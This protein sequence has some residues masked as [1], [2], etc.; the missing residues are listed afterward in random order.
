MSGRLRRSTRTTRGRRASRTPTPETQIPITVAEEVAQQLAGLVPTLVAQL[1]ATL[2]PPT[3][4]TN[5]IQNL[6][7]QLQGNENERP[8][9]YGQFAKCK[10]TTFDGTGGPLKVNRWIE[11]MES[12]MDISHC[13]A[14]NKVRY[15]AV[16]LEGNALT[17]WNG[18]IAR[19][20]RPAAIGMSWE[21]FKALL[22]EEYCPRIER[23]KLE[24]E[25]WTHA[26][27]GS[28]HVAYTPR[29]HELS[30]LC[31]RMV[32][33]D[34]DR[35]ELY[36]RGLTPQ[37]RAL[38][39]ASNPSTLQGAI[40]RAAAITE[41]LVRA[42]TLSKT[43]EKRKDV[44][45]SSRGNRSKKSKPGKAFAANTPIQATP[46]QAVPFQAAHVQRNYAAPRPY[47]GPHPQ[48]QRCS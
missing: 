11:S 12:V 43:S 38:V 10:P 32:Q 31:P 7:Y 4:G 20:T 45:E 23:Q 16:S 15:A 28:N 8:I 17:W 25:F 6:Q 1:A 46:V 34:T 21:D 30:T 42:G 24:M 44:A 13:N 33:E 47:Q 19:R 40:T 48:C 3:G 9:D 27:K 37:V 14:E 29:F 36:I 35:V 26:M 18:I 5:P 39:L 41:D 22:L 2:T